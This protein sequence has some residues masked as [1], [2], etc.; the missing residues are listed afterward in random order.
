MINTDSRLIDF[1]TFK[2][3]QIKWDQMFKFFYLDFSKLLDG[4]VRLNCNCK[5]FLLASKLMEANVKNLEF[6]YTYGGVNESSHV[7]LSHE[8]FKLAEIQ[9]NCGQFE[10]A[11]SNLNRA[12]S[13]GQNVY[14]KES[15]TLR[16]FHDLRDNILKLLN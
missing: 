14:T 15:T 13:I 16:E 10:L 12:I 1:D 11:F 8:L 4:L 2:S 3:R 7:E 5:Q 9:C 6:I